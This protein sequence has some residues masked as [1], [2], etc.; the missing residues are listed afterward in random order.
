MTK[1]YEKALFLFVSIVLSFS[2]NVQNDSKILSNTPSS[3]MK[4]GQYEV[5]SYQNMYTQVD[6]RNQNGDYMHG[7]N[8]TTYFTILNYILLGVSNN[9]RVNLGL[10]LNF[11]TVFADTEISSPLYVFRFQ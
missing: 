7:S 8:R 2:L 10:D 11:R 1:Y 4:K 5:Q 9:Q 3:L 6:F